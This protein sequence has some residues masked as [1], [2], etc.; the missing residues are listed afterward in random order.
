MD[1]TDRAIADRHARRPEYARERQAIWAKIREATEVFGD[2][3]DAVGARPSDRGADKSDRER[4]GRDT[5]GVADHG[6]TDDARTSD[7]ES[8]GVEAP[9]ERPDGNPQI[10]DMRL[11]EGFDDGN[12]YWL[13]R[14]QDRRPPE[15]SEAFDDADKPP[16]SPDWLPP[17]DEQP[18]TTRDVEKL[19]AE[20]VDALTEPSS[21]I[22]KMRA[23]FLKRG[24]DA[25]D[26]AN[27]ATDKLGN[28]IFGRPPDHGHAEVRSP[29][30]V[31][32]APQ[33]AAMDFGELGGAGI[34]LGVLMF[35]AVRKIRRNGNP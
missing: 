1:K 4:G 20:G 28:N 13:R 3:P 19:A 14:E 7:E 27:E 35:Q 8:R 2:R 9:D 33:H 10:T 21:K 15:A 11:P 6:G 26:A 25:V 12:V 17:E 18:T 32:Q 24:D 22:E 34:A 23:E 30:P 29:H 5:D 31:W 16:S